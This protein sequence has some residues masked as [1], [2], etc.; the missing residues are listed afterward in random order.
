MVWKTT[1]LPWFSV[2]MATNFF[3]LCIAVVRVVILAFV[4]ISIFPD[5]LIFFA[6]SWTCSTHTRRIDGLNFDRQ[7]LSALS[8]THLNCPGWRS[9]DIAAKP[10]LMQRFKAA[11]PS[12]Q[13]L[14]TNL[15]H[16]SYRFL[17]RAQQWTPTRTC[18][19]PDIQTDFWKDTYVKPLV[20]LMLL[21]MM[22]PRVAETI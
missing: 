13:S 12:L 4:A 14:G 15:Q 21:K 9:Y 7:A 2:V 3:Q 18:M 10:V 20:K 5:S 8:L 19:T 11:I 17:P 1:A 22:W 16:Q 6:S